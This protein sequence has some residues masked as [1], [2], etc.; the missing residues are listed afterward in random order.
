[1]TDFVSVR[2]AAEELGCSYMKVIRLIRSKQLRADK[3]EGGWGWMVSRI[4][5]ER[6]KTCEKQ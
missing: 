5:V 3:V 1:M 4:D 2:K 6:L